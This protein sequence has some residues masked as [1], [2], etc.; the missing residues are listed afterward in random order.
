MNKIFIPLL[1]ALPLLLTSCATPPPPAPQVYRS[2]G[3]PALVIDSLDDQSSRLL[4]PDLTKE[5]LND[6]TLAHA[7]A[8]GKQPMAVV[9]L[10]N[11]H[12]SQPGDEFHE[13]SVS[14]YVNLRSLGYKQIVFLHGN[15]TPNPDGLLTV[16]KYE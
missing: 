13:R 4:L 14:W 10:E 1:A 9:I 5:A 12:E 8:L 7:K 11:F 6:T 16:A 2:G 15:G 3:G